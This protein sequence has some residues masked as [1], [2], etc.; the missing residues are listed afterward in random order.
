[1][2]PSSGFN[3]ALGATQR[4]C[5]WEGLC[6]RG[7]TRVKFSVLAEAAGDEQG[8][9]VLAGAGAGQVLPREAHKTGAVSAL[10]SVSSAPLW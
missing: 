3:L 2:V 10:T 9:V 6:L 4:A 8:E 7:E 5:S 1:M